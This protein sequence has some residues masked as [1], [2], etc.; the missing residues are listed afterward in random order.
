MW[1]TIV[2]MIWTPN[3]PSE[4]SE[5][6]DHL[7][8][9]TIWVFWAFWALRAL[10]AFRAIQAFQ[11]F[12]AIRVLTMFWFRVCWVSKHEFLLLCLIVWPIILVYLLFTCCILRCSLILFLDLLIFFNDVFI[13]FE[14]FQSLDIISS[15]I[16]VF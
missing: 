6:S 13:P 12:P 10:R 14:L 16:F 4:P 2:F 5:P 15:V 9:W 1:I 7:T 11:A 8:I 3:E